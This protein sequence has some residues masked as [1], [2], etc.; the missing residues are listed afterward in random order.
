MDA[1]VGP[2]AFCQGF[3]QRVMLL[4]IDGNGGI[5]QRLA[6]DPRMGQCALRR[7]RVG[8]CD[9]LGRKQRRYFQVRPLSVSA[10]PPQ[11][12]PAFTYHHRRK[13]AHRVKQTARPAKIASARAAYPC[14]R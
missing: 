14:G 11:R 5:G 12:L 3:E 4:D 10:A 8:L 6:R 9:R 1:D 13:L 7:L 2:F